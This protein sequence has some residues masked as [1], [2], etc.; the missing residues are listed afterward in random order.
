MLPSNWALSSAK[1]A[2]ALKHKPNSWCSSLPRHLR[3]LTEFDLE[4]TVSTR[5]LVSAGR[6]I[7]S[8]VATGLV[9][10]VPP[11]LTP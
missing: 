10:A 1:P 2:L 5:L 11:S 3:N 8:G 9:P 7:A 6:L 4:E